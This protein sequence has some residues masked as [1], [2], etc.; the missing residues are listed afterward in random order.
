MRGGLRIWMYTQNM[1]LIEKNQLAEI[2]I[3]TKNIQNLNFSLLLSNKYSYSTD[4]A[5]IS[6]ITIKKKKS[7]G[8]NF[9][10]LFFPLIF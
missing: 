7:L 4:I 5:S 2:R 6:F 8:S 1:S 10:V 3:T 9:C